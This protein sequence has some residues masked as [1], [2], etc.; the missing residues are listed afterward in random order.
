VKELMKKGGKMGSSLPSRPW[1]G[2]TEWAESLHIRA[3]EDDLLM[4]TPREVNE[5]NSF[6]FSLNWGRIP[7]VW[8]AVPG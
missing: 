1:G 6:H 2:L 4:V 3:D 8:F 5:V 7:E